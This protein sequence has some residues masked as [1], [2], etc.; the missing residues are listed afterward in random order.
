MLKR[1][2]LDKQWSEKEIKDDRLIPRNAVA[3][4]ATQR[5]TEESERTTKISPAIGAVEERKLYH[6]ERKSRVYEYIKILTPHK[7]IEDVVLNLNQTER[8]FLK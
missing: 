1:E 6:L 2:R 8:N 7:V 4:C 3:D 5:W